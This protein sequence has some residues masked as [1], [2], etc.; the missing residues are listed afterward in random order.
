MKK[1]WKQPISVSISLFGCSDAELWTS[2]SRDV[3]SIVKVKPFNADYRFKDTS[4]KRFLQQ[5]IFDSKRTQKNFYLQLAEIDDLFVFL[6]LY[7][8]FFLFLVLEEY[9]YHLFY[10]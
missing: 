3:K 1:I 5:K 2:R 9:R 4:S 6:Y 8:R 10:T 7:F